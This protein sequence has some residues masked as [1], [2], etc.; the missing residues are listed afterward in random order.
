MSSRRCG[1]GHDGQREGRDAR[2]NNLRIRRTTQA[3]RFDILDLSMSASSGRGPAGSSGS[4]AYFS[5]K[6]PGAGVINMR[7][8]ELKTGGF[9]VFLLFFLLGVS[10][11]LGVV[12]VLL[13][14]LFTSVD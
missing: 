1:D 9:K 2:Y 6:G 5:A 14:T 7:F 3:R 12:W 8:K 4:N 11:S 13:V 10:F